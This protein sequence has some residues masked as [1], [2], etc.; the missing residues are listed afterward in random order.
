[1]KKLAASLLLFLCLLTACEHTPT[2]ETAV[3]DAPYIYFEGHR[4]NCETGAVTFLCADPLCGHNSLDCPFF[5]FTDTTPMVVTANKV[6]FY[7][8]A[9]D[10][11]IPITEDQIIIADYQLVSYDIA[12]QH[13]EIIFTYSPPTGKTSD[14]LIYS[15]G[16]IYIQMVSYDDKNQNENEELKSTIY[17]VDTDSGKITELFTNTDQFPKLINVYDGRL[18]FSE[19][20]GYYGVNPDGSDKTEVTVYD[21]GIYTAED[22]NLYYPLNGGICMAEPGNKNPVMIAENAQY[23]INYHNGYVY[24][25]H[26]GDGYTVQLDESVTNKTG[27]KI[28]RISTTDKNAEEELFYDC[29]E[30]VAL[31]GYYTKFVGDYFT[32]PCQ[33]YIRNDDGTV[34]AAENSSILI[35]DTETGE[36]RIADYTVVTSEIII[37]AADIPSSW[38]N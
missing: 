22:G 9:Q 27:G 12:T 11:I 4:F 31:N 13:T 34:T 28:Y 35:V 16:V 38:M 21:T 1:M 24:Y 20:G 32:V 25:Y 30:L 33:K 15:E 8:I 37:P 23:F 6:F 14:S 5:R 17:A 2:A 18:Y 3:S 19:S 10:N 7:R 26:T 29:G 36:S